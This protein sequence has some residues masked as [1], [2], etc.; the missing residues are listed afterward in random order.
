MIG[1]DTSGLELTNDEEAIPVH[2]YLLVEQGVHI[3][4]LHNLEALALDEAWR[5]TYIALTNRIKGAT[6]GFAMRPIAV[7]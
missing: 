6:A 7:R 2:R 4:E 3:A 1:A 5:F